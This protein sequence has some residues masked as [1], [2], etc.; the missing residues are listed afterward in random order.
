MPPDESSRLTFF[1][2]RAGADAELA[3]AVGAILEKAVEAES[4]HLRAAAIFAKLVGVEHP[5][6]AWCLR[7]LA[8]VYVGQRRGTE[9]RASY[10]GALALY[11]RAF[12]ADGEATAALREEIARHVPF[13]APA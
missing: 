13:C 3:A 5:D 10:E 8:R 7:N 1:I 2:S 11:E 4:L 12:G 9:A 6:Y